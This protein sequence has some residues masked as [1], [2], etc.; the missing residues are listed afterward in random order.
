[1]RNTTSGSLIDEPTTGLDPAPTRASRASAGDRRRR[2]GDL[3]GQQG[4]VAPRRSSSAARSTR[5]ATSPASTIDEHV[6]QLLPSSRLTARIRSHTT[7]RA[8]PQAHPLD[9]SARADLRRGPPTHQDH[10]PLPRRDLGTVTDLGR[11][12]TRQ[13]RLAR[14]HHD[15]ESGRRDR[16]PPPPPTP[17]PDR[18][19]DRGGDRG[20][21][22]P[23]SGATSTRIPPAPGTPPKTSDAVPFELTTVVGMRGTRGP[24]THGEVIAAAQGPALEAQ[25]RPARE[26]RADMRAHGRRAGAGRVVVKDDRVV[27]HRRDRLQV[28]RVPGR[29]V[30]IDQRRDVE[31]Y[32]DA[33]KSSCVSIGGSSSRGEKISN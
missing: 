20:L 16:T 21:T 9:E 7:R 13:P 8:A 30:A 14:D 15:P 3:E 18:P 24:L 33:Q 27:M 19:L 17:R 31:N 11:A 4:A 29:V 6:D 5:F 1:M 25:P 26:D 22:L 2:R 28:L 23:H 10:R 32:A 12:R